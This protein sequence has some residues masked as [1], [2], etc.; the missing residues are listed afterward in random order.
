MCFCDEKYT[1]RTRTPAILHVHSEARQEGLKHYTR[2]F[3]IFP[4]DHSKDLSN[5]VIY[6]N[7]EQDTA[8][9]SVTNQHAQSSDD[10][11]RALMSSLYY[12]WACYPEIC[13][14]IR[15]IVIPCPLHGSIFL[16]G[17]TLAHCRVREAILVCNDPVVNR[18]PSG[19]QQP[20][21]TLRF[22]DPSEDQKAVFK[23]TIEELRRREATNIGGGKVQKLPP[24]ITFKL[25]KW[26]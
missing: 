13:N 17:L 5:Q 25:L 8:Y 20:N 23:A 2:I 6:M 18:S 22:L 24:L 11:S 1:S 14:S 21:G 12:Q 7:V 4:F 15:R 19:I 3:K 16:R 9:I 10:R 26:F